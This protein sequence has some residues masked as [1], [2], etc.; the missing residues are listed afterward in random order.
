MDRKD[1]QIHKVISH[2][3]S[4]LGNKSGEGLYFTQEQDCLSE[5]VIFELRLE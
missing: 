5:E 3:I 4:A 2:S 1:K